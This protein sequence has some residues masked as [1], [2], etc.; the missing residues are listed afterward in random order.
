[1]RVSVTE[2]MTVAVTTRSICCRCCC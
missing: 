2:A 1:L